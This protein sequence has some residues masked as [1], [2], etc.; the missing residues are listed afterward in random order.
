MGAGYL[1]AATAV[2]ALVLLSVTGA[3]LAKGSSWWLL[4]LWDLVARW[5][6]PTGCLGCGRALGAGR[7]ELGLCLSCRGRLVTATRAVCDGC[8][9]PLAAAHL[10][11][12]YL[13]GA[14]RLRPPAF[15]RVRAAWVYGPPIDAVIRGLKF[16]RLE[17]LGRHLAH[18]MVESLRDELAECDCVV[19]VPLHWRRRWSRGFDQ[20]RA[21]AEPLAAILDLPLAAPLARRRATPPQ[22]ELDRKARLSSPRGAFRLRRRGRVAGRVVLL[23]DDV[24]TTAATLDAAS[25]VLIQ[26]GALKVIAVAAART[27]TAEESQRAPSRAL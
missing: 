21:I 8:A 4:A 23:V 3:S 26:A 5:L 25:R 11:A 7:N 2:Y 14:C 24:V 20:A 27:P 9:R 10:P 17:Y 15:D 18:G 12:G 1:W 13:C 22:S 16:E 19:A 6:F